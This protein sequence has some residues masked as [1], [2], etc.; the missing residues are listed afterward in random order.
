MC[1]ENCIWAIWYC[2]LVVEC[3]NSG[4]C[5]ELEQAKKE[6]RVII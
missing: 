6:G 5:E 3:C 4:D 2:G 1:C